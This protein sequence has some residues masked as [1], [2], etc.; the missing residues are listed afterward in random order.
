MLIF[1][2]RPTRQL[3]DVSSSSAHRCV[4]LRRGDRAAI[5]QLPAY[6]SREEASTGQCG[7]FCIT[8]TVGE[9]KTSEGNPENSKRDAV[10]VAPSVP[11]PEKG[12]SGETNTDGTNNGGTNNGGTNRGRGGEG[13]RGRGRERERG[14]QRTKKQDRPDEKA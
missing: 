5:E 10:D 9:D 4:G 1:L 7:S 12:S 8:T 13:E 2:R 3:T 11:A 14:G 6:P